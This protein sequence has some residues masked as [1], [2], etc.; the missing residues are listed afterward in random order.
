MSIEHILTII[1][2][3]VIPAIVTFLTALGIFIK[4]ILNDWKEFKNA[5]KP[6]LEKIDSTHHL[7]RE[8]GIQ[9][10]CKHEKTCYNKKHG[11]K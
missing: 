11:K 4:K 7:L 5:I 8:N 6:R 3:T 9:I 1:A 2:S 10:I